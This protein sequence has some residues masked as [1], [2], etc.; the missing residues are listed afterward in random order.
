[1]KK[2]NAICLYCGSSNFVEDSYKEAAAEAGKLLAAAGIRLIYGGGH[3]GLMGVA[4][5]AALAG[6]GEVVGIIPEHIQVREVR[7]SHLTELH[8]VDSMH[9][10]KNMMFEMAD[11]FIILPGGLGTLDETFEILTWRQLGLHDKPV[12]I[13]NVNGFWDPMLALIDGIIDKGFA[14]PENRG[15]FVVVNTVREILGVL[16]LEPEPEIK[17]EILRL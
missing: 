3:V 14:R 7:H 17:T 8:V 12:I 4:A 10:R 2:I 16:A 6:G 9:T 1:M 15:L 11:A 13:V 5:D